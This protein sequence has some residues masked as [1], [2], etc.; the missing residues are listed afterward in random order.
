MN[1]SN[2]DRALTAYAASPT[3]AT[4]AAIVEAV[5]P[6]LTAKIT[7]LTACV[8]AYQDSLKDRARHVDA[9]LVDPGQLAATPAQPIAKTGDP[10]PGFVLAFVRLD[11][12]RFDGLDAP[13][14][15]HTVSNGPSLHV[16]L[17]GWTM[18]KSAQPIAPPSEL[19]ASSE[20]GVDYIIGAVESYARYLHN[21]R[22]S[23]GTQVEAVNTLAR[24][25][26]MLEDDAAKLAAAQSAQP[27]A[28]AA[29]VSAPTD[30]RAAYP[31]VTYQQMRDNGEDIE[32]M[33]ATMEQRGR[34]ESWPTNMRDRINFGLHAVDKARAGR[35]AARAAAPSV[36]APTDE[37]AA[38]LKHFP[39]A[40]WI[41]DEQEFYPVSFNNVFQ[42]WQAARAAEPD[43]DAL[44][45]E[46]DMYRTVYG[47]KI[48]A[49]WPDK[50]A[51]DI[52]IDA[53]SSALKIE[54]AGQR[55]KGRCG[56]GDPAQCATQD[57]AA[58]M[59]RQ[60]ENGNILAVGAY[61]MMLFN[62][63]AWPADLVGAMSLHVM[64]SRRA[65]APVSGP[66]DDLLT[67]LANE[68]GAIVSTAFLDSVQIAAAQVEKRMFVLGALGFVHIP[69]SAMNRPTD[70]EL[71]DKTLR[72]RDTYHEWA[73][74]LADAIAKHFGIEIGEHSNQNLPWAEALDHIEAISAA[75]VSGQG[76]SVA[77]DE[78]LQVL[79]ANYYLSD[80]DA[81]AMGIEREIFAYID[82]IIDS[83]PR[84]KDSR[85]KVLEEAA[86]AVSLAIDNLDYQYGTLM[87]VAALNGAQTK[88]DSALASTT[89]P[90]ADNE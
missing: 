60:I 15:H 26:R 58:S 45:V 17:L 30:E 22:D 3:P 24:I 78:G 50:H 84:S 90:K 70:D 25:R 59:V 49:D 51:D 42:G 21:G 27:I 63:D 89:P 76:A 83:R 62:R 33:L 36:S 16:D 40:R 1:E 57:L 86:I 8:L 13:V 28:P 79:L 37:R 66:S 18:T 20:R 7:D 41:E 48:P 47:T 23:F 67:T 85:A 82:R 44:A 38:F 72:D 75:P 43:T 32:I 56:W 88:L 80:E 61:A 64:A 4:K 73:D 65:A 12:A 77:D 74:K 29:D 68:G 5:A 2:L 52:A 6:E 31:A 54:M 53:F 69:K 34:K 11:G 35:I 19:S 71:W 87:G 9:M 55:A 10:L 81:E 46:L 39:T 14:S